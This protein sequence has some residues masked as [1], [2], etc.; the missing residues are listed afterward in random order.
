VF[1]EEQHKAEIILGSSDNRQHGLDFAAMGMP[2]LNLSCLDVCFSEEE[3]SSV[4][5]ALPADKASGPDGFLALFYQSAWPIVKKEV[6]AVFNAFWLLDHY[7]F[8][9]VNQAYVVLL[10]KKE[11]LVEVQDFRQISLIHS[12]SKLITKVLSLRLAPRMH[13]LIQQNQ[14]GCIRGRALHDNFQVVQSMAKLLHARRRPSIV[15]KV[16]IVKA[17]DTVNWASL[18]ELLQFSDFS[19]QME[20]LGVHDSLLGQ[21]Y[22]NSQWAAMPSHR[23]C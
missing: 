16:N 23:S 6:V 22:D 7:S 10:C 11:D 3:I 8:Y 17:I 12:I 18:L 20:Q 14:S 2:V 4:V 5:C 19:R 9:H 1:I 13:E 21:Y 15:L